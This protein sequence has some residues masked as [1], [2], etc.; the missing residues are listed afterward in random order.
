MELRPLGFDAED[1]LTVRIDLPEAGYEDPGARLQF[2]DRAR[3]VISGLPGLGTVELTNV[4][5]G[6]GFGSLRSL[7]IEGMNQ[8]EDR[9][10][11]T[12]LMSTVSQGYFTLLGLPMQ[13]G[14][15]FMETDNASS[16]PVAIV[17]AEVAGR[18]WP[19]EAPV[20]RRFRVAGTEEWYE[21]VGVVSDVR[22]ASESERPSLSIYLPHPQDARGS[23]YLVSRTGRAAAEV[24]GPI[25]AAIWSIDAGQPVDA[26]QTMER[27]QYES[28]A[29]TFALLTLFVTFAVFALLM[30]AIGIYGVMA[31]SVSQRKNEIG[32]RI[33][34]GADVATVRW[35]VL[36]QGSRLTAVG[37]AIGL[38][39]AF[40]L[41]RML[42]SLVFGISATDPATFIGVT[43]ILALV[44]LVANLIPARRATRL[45][46]AVALRSD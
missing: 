32:V 20:G 23:M 12:A 16:F 9:A 2:F 7:E 46:P 8:P 30:A 41:S 15:G 13:S 18:L 24:A 37:I 43:L 10:A 5:A 33:A 35:M 36:A 27:A 4:L 11:P 3:E 28:S 31:Y 14:R 22:A 40:G 1:L 38:V 45:D 25:R 29:S 42:G 17:S 44:A 39:A 26:I 19:N 6:I 21:V 34:L